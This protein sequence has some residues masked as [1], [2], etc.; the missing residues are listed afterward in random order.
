MIPHLNASFQRQ[1]MPILLRKTALLLHNI[2]SIPPPKKDR[3]AQKCPQ[4]PEGSL[5][6]AMLKISAGYPQTNRYWGH[7]SVENITRVTCCVHVRRKYVN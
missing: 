3:S 4:P 2:T 6:P 7:N 5:S 1:D